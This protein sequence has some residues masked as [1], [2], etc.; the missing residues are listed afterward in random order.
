MLDQDKCEAK[1][2]NA[3]RKSRILSVFAGPF[4]LIE[5]IAAAFSSQAGSG[6]RKET[7]ANQKPGFREKQALQVLL[8]SFDRQPEMLLERTLRDP[9]IRRNIGRRIGHAIVKPCE[10]E[11]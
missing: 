5:C 10:G 1:S 9:A 11:Q 6:S 8:A 2:G 4:F 7:V 3:L